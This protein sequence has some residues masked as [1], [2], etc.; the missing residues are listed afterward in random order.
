MPTSSR[1]KRAASGALDVR[2]AAPA[3]PARQMPGAD[4]RAATAL[5]IAT[6][7]TNNIRAPIRAG[8]EPFRLANKKGAV[9]AA[10]YI[11]FTTKICFC[12]YF[13]VDLDKKL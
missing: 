9:F 11:Y 8:S 12:K 7:K 3:V 2:I 13:F 5:A 10:P 6:K 4:A 1:Q